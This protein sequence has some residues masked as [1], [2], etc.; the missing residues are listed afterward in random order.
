VPTA[1]DAEVSCHPT[2]T[3]SI[4]CRHPRPALTKDY[5]LHAIVTGGAGFIGSHL[6]T[7][8]L[9]RDFTVTCVDNL[10]TG[11]E[12]NI[13]ELR[14]HPRFQFVEHDVCQPLP[15]VPRSD[16]IFH[17]ASPASVADYLALPLETL[18]VNT[19]GTLNL[20]ELAK[21]SGA[22]FLFASTSEVYGD[23]LEHPQQESYWGN[24][25]PNGLRSVYAESKRLGEAATM[26]YWRTVE[27]DARL[28]R[29]FNTYGPHSRRDDGRI[30]PN[31]ITQA[32]RHEPLTIY[33]DGSHT[34]SY[35]Y[36]SDLVAG[37]IAAMFGEGTR[38]EVFNIGNPD[39][40]TVSEF[41]RVIAAQVG[42]NA[43]V[44][45]EPLPEDDPSRRKPDITKAR[46]MLGWEPTVDLETGVGQTIR[47]FRGLLDLA[48]P[49]TPQLHS[50]GAG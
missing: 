5:T 20:L 39:E 2:P 18:R 30:V 41:A 36:V 15:G 12:Q 33:G 7:T 27:V 45:Y 1:P 16:V 34:R 40:Y 8:L 25:D 23:P 3:T 14:A 32:L 43:G 11:S 22:R 49:L 46:T 29:I 10:V 24:V 26:A 37:I 50:S 28:V 42:S 19:I 47:W 4:L 35:C 31:F 48:E 44:I 38:G 6:C 17:L 9:A 13:V 21:D